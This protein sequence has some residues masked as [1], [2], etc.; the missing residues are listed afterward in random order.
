MIFLYAHNIILTSFQYKNVSVENHAVKMIVFTIPHFYL[1]FT[2][3]TFSKG[4][5]RNQK[6][7]VCLYSFLNI[8]LNISTQFRVIVVFESTVLLKLAKLQLFSGP[9]CYVYMVTDE[10]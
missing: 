5:L 9:F 8:F 6:L 4:F 7:M 2:T 10:A 3:N 1:Y